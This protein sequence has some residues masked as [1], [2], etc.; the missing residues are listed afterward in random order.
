MSNTF[1]KATFMALLVYGTDSAKP[2][3]ILFYTG[4]PFTENSVVFV[5]LLKIAPPTTFYKE[6]YRCEQLLI[7]SY[8]TVFH[9]ITV[10]NKVHCILQHD[11]T[12]ESTPL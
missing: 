8:L 6:T 5:I 1:L 2:E 9:K 12:V 7:F 10:L 11:H 4:V 3:M